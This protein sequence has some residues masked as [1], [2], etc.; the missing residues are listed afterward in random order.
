MDWKP[1][2]V[3]AAN[4][5]INIDDL[6]KPIAEDKPCGEDFTYHPTFQNLETL[7]RGKPETQ[8]SAAEEPD[9]KEVRDA[10]LEVLTQSKHLA[11]AVILT[12]ALLRLGG[13]DGLG[14]GLAVV[15]G[16]TEKYWPTLYPQMDPEDNNDPTER[17]NILNDL[18]SSKFVRQ[19]GELVLCNSPTMG[20]ITLQQ[21]LAAKER[22]DKPAD[23]E[24][25]PAAGPDI[26]Q[27]K[28]AFKDAGPAP[29]QAAFNSVLAAAEQAR[30]IETFLDTTLG[31]SR[32][33]N[34]ESLNKVLGDMKRVLEPFREDGAGPA[35]EVAEAGAPG[36]AAGNGGA[37]QPQGKRGPGMSGTIQS[38][39][40]VMKAL[41]L[42]CEYYRQHEPSS[43][44]PLI[45]QRAHRLVDKD[46]MAIVSDLTP[47]ALTHL[48]VITG[49]K[50]DK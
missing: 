25:P 44:V 37:E 17:I 7:A 35:S 39:G 12:R 5:M 9:W 43:P 1:W 28:A 27:I 33:V 50:T 10:A 46:F 34:F 20:R 45:L 31:A 18:S 49:T 11:A 19:L 36:V 47:D 6:L 29:A 41:D 32:G 26:N 15:R 22:S 2:Q 23:S 42:I 48:Q 30:G 13:L 38:R 16:L 4:Y 14:E 3:T 8:F 24:A 40:D 21:I